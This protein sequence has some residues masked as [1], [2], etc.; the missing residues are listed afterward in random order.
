MGVGVEC[1]RV[2][3]RG[4]SSAPTQRTGGGE[5]VECGFEITP[6]EDGTRQCAP[7]QD[8][9]GLSDRVQGQWV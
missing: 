4:L 2:S 7:F 6:L 9:G 1:V 5:G 8:G 3:D